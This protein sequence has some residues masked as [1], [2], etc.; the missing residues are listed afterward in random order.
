MR[1]VLAGRIQESYGITLDEVEKQIKVF[2]ERN[3]D[4]LPPKV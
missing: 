2:E 3:K 4:L 1:A